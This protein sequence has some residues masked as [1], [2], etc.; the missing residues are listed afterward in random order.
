[1]AE[2]FSLVDRLW[3]RC[4]LTD[5]TE[6]EVSIRQVFDGSTGIRGVRG[7]SPTQDYAVLRLLLAIYWRAHVPDAQ[8]APG[9]TYDHGGWFETQ[10]AGVDAGEADAA[11]LE[12]LE[13]WGDRFD[14]LHPEQPFMQVADL[15]TGSGKISGV[16]RM[17]PEAESDDFTMR[18]G[19]GRQSLGLAEAARWLVHLQAYDYSGIKSGA[20]GDPRVK[21]GR[22]YPIGTGWS[23]MT[24]GTVIVGETLRHTLLFN[25]VEEALAREDDH[26]V[27]ERQPDDPAERKDPT[28]KGAADLATWQSRRVRLHT[29]GD[30][31]T[32]VLVS[33]GDKIPDAGA[34]V[35]DD[36]MTPYRYSRNKSKRDHVVYY[37][38]PYD[39]ERTMW[40]SLE[41]LIIAEKDEGYGE[42]NDSRSKKD[43]PPKRPRTL[44]QVA[45]FENDDA[46]P[47]WVDLQLVSTEYGPQASTMGTTVATHI[48]LPR[49][50]LAPS[51]VSTRRTLIDQAAATSDAAVALGRF[52]GS[53]LEAAGGDYEFQSSPTDALLKELEPEFLE[54]IGK[55]DRE[56]LDQAV[57]AWQS[58]VQE[59]ILS[60]ARVLLRGAGPKALVGKTVPGRGD[61]P[62][63][64]VSAGSAYRSLQVALRKALPTTAVETNPETSE[65][66]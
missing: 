42:E 64:I 2:S 23:G 16:S 60:Q 62:D 49:S 15:A 48:E 30:L 55:L 27:W 25:T 32:G 21:G 61:G 26:P 1:M 33:N 14:L 41:P 40:R 19:A 18:A 34:N 24:G 65:E 45:E 11:V 31:V 12:Y 17:I 43:L 7:D 46:A 9:E 54:W 57:R 56:G 22:G 28:P 20:L 36:P 4:Q 8:P 58:T 38:R 3:I 35:S 39:L 29:E 10:L 37:P 5:G 13:K 51:A 59:T 53:L 50:L 6:A 63:S 66:K 47:D 44:D 52:A